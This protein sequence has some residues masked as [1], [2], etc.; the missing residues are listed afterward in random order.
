M[1]STIN[2]TSGTNAGALVRSSDATGNLQIQTQ[3]LNAITI[4]N[5]QN[6]KFA[7]TGAMTFPSGNNAQRPG[8]LAGTTAINGSVRYSTTTNTFEIYVS[9]TWT[10]F[11]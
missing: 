11:V 10:T 8:T 2:C 6:L 5:Q 9:G 3:G 1:A 4:D 7:S